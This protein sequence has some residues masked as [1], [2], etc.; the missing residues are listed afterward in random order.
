MSLGYVDTYFRYPPIHIPGRHRGERSPSEDFP[1]V[2]AND[3][4]F[5]QPL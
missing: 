4:A 3:T 1:G 2:L 5:L